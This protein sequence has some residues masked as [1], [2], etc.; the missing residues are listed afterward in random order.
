MLQKLKPGFLP[1][2]CGSRPLVDTGLPV[3]LCQDK[4]RLGRVLKELASGE[5]EIQGDQSWVCE[6][7]GRE[8]LWPAS[9][10]PELLSAALCP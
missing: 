4:N 8:S 10:W 3:L 2:G 5:E 6:V 9:Q 1:S 7:L